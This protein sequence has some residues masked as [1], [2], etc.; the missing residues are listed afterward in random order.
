[1]SR[2]VGLHCR[3]CQTPYPTGP[4]YVCAR[5]FGPLEVT[6]DEAAIRAT[7]SRDAIAA[8]PAGIWRYLELLPVE[9]PPARSLPVG[10]T[11]LQ[12]AD[13]LGHQLD[14]P[15]LWL[16]NDSLN[17]TLSFKDRVV[18]LGVAR[19]VEFGFDTVA[20]ASTGNLAG[21]VAAAAA[22]SGLGCYVFVPA[23]LEAA[24]IRQASAF[25]AT[26]VPIDGTYDQINRLSVE[27]SD[28]L[29]WAFVNVTLRPYYSEGSKTLPYEIAEQLGWRLPD[30]LVIPIASGS[31]FTKVAK[32]IADLV[33]YGLVEDR[34]VKLIGAQ[35]AGCA[36]VA[37][38]WLA[39]QEHPI[40]VRQPATIVKSLAI[41]DP[42]DGAQV[43]ALA[44]ACKGSVEAVPDDATSAAIRMLAT[45]EG[46]FTETA[47]GVT[48]AAL[49]QARA[50]GV[51]AREDEVVALVTGNGLK[52]PD[53]AADPQAD[54]LFRDGEIVPD[55]R[56]PSTYAAFERWLANRAPA[57]VGPIG[58]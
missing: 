35:P 24:K 2:I 47:G 56:I 39:G 4:S 33:R 52:T 42:A 26:I 30:A 28:E 13:R 9:S 43:L 53:A 29:G 14:T 1:M 18:A 45:S 8:R 38:A 20:C 44:R 5:C 50:S 40:P 49:A 55:A 3:A 57:T 17:P 27:V 37:D 51:I 21:A 34:P 41:G 6:Y 36:P 58:V 11:P 32:G 23:D 48:L 54:A 7:I 25:G 15:N 16:K 31:Q 12:R 19:A 22:A 10:S 46:V